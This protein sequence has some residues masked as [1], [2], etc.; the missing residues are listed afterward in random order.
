MQEGHGGEAGGLL[1]AADGYGPL[2]QRDY[3][4]VVAACRRGPAGVMARV[5]EHIERVAPAEIAAFHRDAGCA[6]ELGDELHVRIAGAGLAHVR[7]VHRDAQSLTLATL[8]GHP[9]AGRITFGAYRNERG[10]VVFHIRSRAR[11]GSALKYLGWRGV[12]EAMQTNTWIDFVNRVAA[13]AGDGVVGN[14]T[15]DT[16]PIAEE[17]EDVARTS[18]TFL[19]RGD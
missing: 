10:D 11:A 2:L 17:P 16:Q 13:A 7:V 4:A 19:A 9:E 6:L 15:A 18:P 12:G 3:W 8:A 1:P 14:I 5:A